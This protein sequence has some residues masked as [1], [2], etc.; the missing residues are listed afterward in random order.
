VPRI[1]LLA[2]RVS[3]GEYLRL[4]AAAEAAGLAPSAWVRHQ[5]LHAADLRPEPVPRFQP[6]PAASVASAASAASASAAAAPPARLAR[7]AGTRFTTE[8]LEALA[9]H[10]RACGLTRAAYI[11]QVVLGVTPAA[12]RPLSHAAIVA[13]NRVG[14]NLNQL[15]HLA[16]TGVVLPPDLRRAVEEVRRAV[17]AL[18]DTL[19]TA[20]LAEPA[21][22]IDPADP[23][24]PS[25]G[26]AAP[27]APPAPA[28][29]A[30]PPHPEP[31][32]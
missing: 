29:P 24:Q 5:A 4:A 23:P 17:Q 1:K 26:P 21:G 15:V 2:V 16:H 31:P 9:D 10:A 6:P 11:R 18:R 7:T 14:N 19:L 30:E 8:H 22:A 32:K 28:A 13:V 25:A 12:R 3:A 20:D 27:A